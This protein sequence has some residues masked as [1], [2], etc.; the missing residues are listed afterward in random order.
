MAYVFFRFYNLSEKLL[1]GF[2]EEIK[3]IS[4]DPVIRTEIVNSDQTMNP[5]LP[6]GTVIKEVHIHY[7]DGSHCENL[8]NTPGVRLVYEHYSKQSEL[9]R[10]AEVVRRT[11]KDTVWSTE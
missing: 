5:F 9:T 2:C 3:R 10:N 7:S 6:V 11:P 8:H 4:P 1:D